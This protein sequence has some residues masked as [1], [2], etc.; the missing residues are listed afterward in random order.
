MRSPELRDGLTVNKGDMTLKKFLQR[1][2]RE[3]THEMVKQ[4]L[5]CTQAQR[6][7]NY[8]ELEFLGDAVIDIMLGF[9]S[10]LQLEKYKS[11]A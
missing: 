4:A 5:T 8:E 11:E 2:E 10:F 1:T 9:E 7:T 3:R 6:E